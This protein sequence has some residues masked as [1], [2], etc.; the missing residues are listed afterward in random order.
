MPSVLAAAAYAPREPRGPRRAPPCPVYDRPFR[1]GAPAHYGPSFARWV[2]NR[3][4]YSVEGNTPTMTRV[5]VAIDPR[6]YRDVIAHAVGGRRPD[7]EVRTVEP[8]DLDG[9]ARRLA[10]DLIV[11]NRATAAVRELSRSWVEIEVRLGPGSLNAN[12]K[13]DGRPATKV[14]QAEIEHVVAALDETERTLL[15]RR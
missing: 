15:L 13:V 8:E 6:L 14:E 5:L 10:P 2:P 4:V 12:V 11:C 3:L 7:A 9:E 1:F